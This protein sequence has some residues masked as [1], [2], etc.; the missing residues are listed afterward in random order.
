MWNV[1]ESKIDLKEPAR[2][3]LRNMLWLNPSY[4]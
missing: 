2:K 4:N 1:R 3:Q